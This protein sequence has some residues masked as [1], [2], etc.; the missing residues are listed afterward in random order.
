M[1]IYTFILI[2]RL[3]SVNESRGEG[4]LRKIEKNTF[5]KYTLNCHHNI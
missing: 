2:L 4:F 3:R 1:L 5:N